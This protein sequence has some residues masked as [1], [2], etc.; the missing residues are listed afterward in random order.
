MAELGVAQFL[1]NLQGAYD[2]RLAYQEA[3]R[4]IA[5][6]PTQVLP[7]SG[8]D[9]GPAA[10]RTRGDDAAVPALGS[11]PNLTFLDNFPVA[12]FPLL[13]LSSLPRNL[14]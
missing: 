6:L 10:P 2:I 14:T 3:G 5:H 13:S 8:R 11:Q 9:T 7:A 4:E 12:Y 1:M